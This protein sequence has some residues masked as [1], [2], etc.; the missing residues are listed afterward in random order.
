LK[1]LVISI[2]FGP[3]FQRDLIQ[4]LTQR[5]HEVTFFSAGRFDPSRRPHLRWSW[6][7]GARQVELINSPNVPGTTGDPNWQSSHPV[8]EQLTEQV[9]DQVQPDVVHVHE[10]SGHCLSILDLIQA[11]G[12]PSVVSFHN[13]WPICPQLTLVDASGVACEDYAEGEKCTRCY[14]LPPV[15]D[16]LW[17]DQVKSVLID[18]PMFRPVR[19]FRRL[20]R[21]LVQRDNLGPPQPPGWGV[22]RYAAAAFAQRRHAAIKLLNQANVIHAMSTRSAAV[23]L[24]YG[25]LPDRIKVIPIS[26]F[27]LDR[28]QPIASRRISYP[29]TF[30]YRGNLSY[31]K[32]VHL[33]IEA[34]AQLDQTRGRL[35][36]YGSGEPKYEAQLRHLGSGLN[37]SFKGEYSAKELTRINSQ[38][39]VGVI[40][41]ISDETFCLVGIEF[42]QSGIP[43]I[44]SR[45]GGMLDYVE[46]QV[47][48][49]LV[50]PRDVSLLREA[51]AICIESPALLMQMRS[52]IRQNYS[53]MDRV[54]NSFLQL[55]ADI[56]KG[57]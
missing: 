44:A 46:D 57:A 31:V 1:I 29:I 6:S 45:M 41:S 35:L 7:V 47:S 8:I 43:V 26:L 16:R 55:Y 3:P 20:T 32:G 25:I 5:G 15:A 49:L 48:G 17:V 14:W 56:L 52:K 12:I 28:L 39:D 54:S 53:S 4:A 27:S 23:L 22:P 42:L 40:P 34:F 10:I 24:S 21:R 50:N 51:M 2:S 37:L 33:L 13:Y 30:G 36:I 9:L 19:R 11:R 38:I 18:T